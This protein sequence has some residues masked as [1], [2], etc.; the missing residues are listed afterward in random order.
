MPNCVNCGFESQ[1]DFR[2]CPE[3]G[4][5]SMG[6][7]LG[8][9]L[10]GRTLAGKYRVIEEI[11]AG[12]MGKVYRAEQIALKKKV[13]I[14][15][16]HRDLQVNDEALQRLQRE[17]IAAGQVS[18]P[19]VIQIFDFERTDDGLFFLA[20]EFV[21]V[22]TIGAENEQELGDLIRRIPGASQRGWPS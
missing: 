11:G 20:M 22:F 9:P 12:S 10:L 13:A 5:Q 19:N 16:L 2:F 1:D 3:C 18:H 8:D 4:T 14:K 17:G 7:A 6:E 21:D 15:L